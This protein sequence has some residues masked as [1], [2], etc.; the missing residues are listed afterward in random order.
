MSDTHADLTANGS[1]GDQALVSGRDMYIDF[2]HIA[3]GFCVK[4]KAFITSIQDQFTS[5]WNSQDVYGRMDPLMTFQNTQRVV[6]LGFSVPAVNLEEAKRNMHALEHLIMQ[7]YP[8]YQG[9][10]IAGSPLMKIKFANLIKSATK[11]HNSPDAK[12]SGLVAAV[13]GLTFAPDME[14]GF[15]I[16][17]AG[18]VIPKSFL[19]D[20]SFTVLHDHPL[21]FKKK[22]LWRNNSQSFPYVTA[23]GKATGNLSRC[24]KGSKI[25]VGEF[26]ISNTGVPEK[27]K[28]FKIKQ[29]TGLK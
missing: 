14:S 20:L 17:S 19:I 4:F 5:N 27:V 25:G 12:D 8:T 29:L 6:N 23:P 13:Q 16:P 26:N 7:L 22:G 1:I 21:G 15:F 28:A 2:Y 9:E 11:K 18:Q 10:V 3:T 24:T